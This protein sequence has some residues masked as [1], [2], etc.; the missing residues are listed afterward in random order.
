L[1]METVKQA[2]TLVQQLDSPP[3]QCSSLEGAVMQFLVQKLITEIEHPLYSPNL[4]P[5]DFWLWLFPSLP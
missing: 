5:N 2:S 3:W 1:D 4:A